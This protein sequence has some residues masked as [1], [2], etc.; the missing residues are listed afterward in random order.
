MKEKKRI[1]LGFVEDITV[2]GKNGK[3]KKVRARIDTGA[4]K[5]AVDKA[6]VKEFKLGPICGKRLVKSSNGESIRPILK[7]NIILCKQKIRNEFTIADRSKLR[8]KVLIGQNILKT[9]G[10]IIDPLKKK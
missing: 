2:V 4:T 10:F 3:K 6:I 7:V 5:S 1:L 9:R 8:Y